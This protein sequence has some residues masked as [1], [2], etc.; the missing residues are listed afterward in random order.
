LEGTQGSRDFGQGLRYRVLDR[1]SQVK[2]LK[3]FDRRGQGA[4]D[5]F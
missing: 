5:F 3:R 2:V 1:D 4:R